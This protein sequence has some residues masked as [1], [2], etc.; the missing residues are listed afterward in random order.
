MKILGE[1]SCPSN[2]HVRRACGC[3][4]RA[5]R[6][7]RPRWRHAD[8]DESLRPLE[9]PTG[10]SGQRS[11]HFN[12][13]DLRRKLLFTLGLLVVFR[14]AAHVPVPNVDH[15]A[16]TSVLNNNNLL[17]MFNIFSGGS[18]QNFSIVAMGVYPY[19][20]ASIVMQLLVPIIPR[21]EEL[22]KRAS[23][24]ATRSTSTPAC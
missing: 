19:I 21:M 23:T 16:L 7:S 5:R 4:L 20:T 1:A 6:R 12:V 24:G 14:I 9:E 13:P 11:T 3:R 10:D 8:R 15:A 22:R 17:Q 18:L 2:L